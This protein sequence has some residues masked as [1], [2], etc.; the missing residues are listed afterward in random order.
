[1]GN[2]RLSSM[3]RA[4]FLIPSL[5][6]A[7]PLAGNHGSKYNTTKPEHLQVFEKLSYSY[8]HC[9]YDPPVPVTIS[10]VMTRYDTPEDAAMSLMSAMGAM[11]YA[12]FYRGWTPE[13][14]KAMSEEDKS[15]HHSQDYWTKLWAKWLRGKKVAMTDRV[16]TGN[17]VIIDMTAV[18]VKE[19]S[20]EETAQFP[21]VLAKDSKGH[22]LATQ[23][24]S[25][26]PVLLN[27]PRP[28]FV[29]ERVIR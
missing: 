20:G 19:N 27:W 29:T 7:A 22:W 6:A 24:L 21:W 18:P 26:D 3:R 15:H 28:N 12:S 1:M 8:T 2:H 17:Y 23:D 4:W 9:K 13:A 16:E 5:L 11:D 10:E 25:E 14:Q